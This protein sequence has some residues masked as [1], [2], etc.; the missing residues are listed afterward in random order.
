[1]NLVQLLDAYISC[2]KSSNTPRLIDLFN[3]NARLIDPWGNL[4]IGRHEIKA[5][6]NDFFRT[7]NIKHVGSE[8]L[9]ESI[10][11]S[12]MVEG[13]K[14][15]VPT[16]AINYIKTKNGLVQEAEIVLLKY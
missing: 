14:V 10:K 8:Q 3:S 9:G 7:M 1:M 6:Y 12:Y 11:I 16:R 5:F 15:Q 2:E 13:G 4:H